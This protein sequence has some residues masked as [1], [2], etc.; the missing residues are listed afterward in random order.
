MKESV[1]VW[2][3]RFLFAVAVIAAYKTFDNFPQ[4]LSGLREILRLLRPFLY[5]VVIAFLLLPP[6][7]SLEKLLRRPGKAWLDKRARG[8]S[9]AT[10]LA[11]FV[12]LLLA[13]LVWFVPALY[14][15]LYSFAVSLPGHLN[16]LYQLAVDTFGNEP[17]L[18]SLQEQL[19]KKLTLEALLGLLSSLNVAGYAAGLSSAVGLLVDL[20]LAMI[21]SIYILA[22]RASLRRNL[23]RVL[24]LC[25]RPQTAAELRLLTVRIANVLYSF[26]Y[27]QA[28]DALM[29][30]VLSWLGFSLLRIPNA[31]MLGFFYG[32]FSLIPYFGAFI[33]VFT[34]AIFTL[35]S[36]GPAKMLVALVFILVLQQIDGNI[37]N[38][39]I[40]G[41]SI[42][43]KPLYVIFGATFFGGLFGIA[44]MLL[45]PPI[46]AILCELTDNFLQRR[47]AGT[48]F[49][50]Q[51][52]Q[53][54]PAEQAAHESS[55]ESQ[56]PS[57]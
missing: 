32:L 46:M 50:F 11:I 34:V 33:G 12:L 52:E 51:Q 48:P 20:F 43:I 53:S 7:R 23:L 45:G 38:P 26:L 39:K 19:S 9:A 22:D 40:I 35:I 37:I 27:G 17:W 54:A 5:G 6:A 55:P 1:R 16:R 31:A 15:S 28:M 10:C 4:L 49:A 44:G 56:N 14:Q 13:M 21:L 41:D 30:G 25:C 8:I 47:E 24:H 18:Q 36:G 3:G 42:G 29:V 57:E 2:G